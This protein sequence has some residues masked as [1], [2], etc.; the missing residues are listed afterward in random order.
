MREV[1]ML[2]PHTQPGPAV[3]LAGLAVGASF[4]RTWQSLRIVGARVNLIPS[5]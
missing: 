3:R 5:L 2:N 4:S 1:D